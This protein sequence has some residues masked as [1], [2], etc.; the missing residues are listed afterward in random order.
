MQICFPKTEKNVFI[1]L[2]RQIEMSMGDKNSF[3]SISGIQVLSKTKPLETIF[4]CLKNDCLVEAI[5]GCDRCSK[6]YCYVPV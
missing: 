5:T 1:Y 4:N 6:Y 3:H 2:L